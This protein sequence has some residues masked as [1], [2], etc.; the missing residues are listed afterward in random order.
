MKARVTITD[1]TRMQHDHVC[2]AGYLPNDVCVRPVFPSGGL[3][4]DWLKARGQVIIRPFAVVEFILGQKKSDPP[5]TEDRIVD[6]VYRAPCGMLSNQERY[7]LLR[8]IL[9]PN[10]DEI[11]GAEIREGPGRYILVG[12]GQRSLGTVKPQQI[13]AVSYTQNGAGE[14]RYRIAFVDEAGDTYY[15]SVSDLAFRYYLDHLRVRQQIDPADI[16]QQ[17]TATLQDSIVFLRIG[18]TRGWEKYPDRH[19]LQ[20]TGV[21]TFPDYLEG[22]CF[23]DFAPLDR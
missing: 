18:L 21:H 3:M 9:D 14:W 2:V 8:R 7:D 22:R 4:E 16:G 23:D 15:L 12:Q 1:L 10:V 17:I 5:H 19:F 6:R 11:F 13:E 20:I